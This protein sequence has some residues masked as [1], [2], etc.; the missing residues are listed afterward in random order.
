MYRMFILYQILPQ[1]HQDNQTNKSE[2]MNEFQPLTEK[3][4]EEAL[5][6]EFDFEDRRTMRE[7]KEDL[8]SILGRM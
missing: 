2:N 5:R 6:Y 4:A 7:L 8:K 1:W 3:E